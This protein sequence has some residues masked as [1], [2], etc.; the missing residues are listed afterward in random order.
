MDALSRYLLIPADYSPFVG[1]LRWSANGEAIEYDDGT[2]FVFAP[3]LAL[4]LEGLTSVRRPL[5]FA[6]VLHLLYLLG[7]GK[8]EGDFRPRV[9]TRAFE[10][11]GRP[12]RNAGTLCG[13]LCRILPGMTESFD[14]AQLCRRL[15]SPALMVE[16]R[17]RM[18]LGDSDVDSLA[19][20]PLESPALEKHFLDA[21]SRFTVKEL[22]QWLRYGCIPPSDAGEEVARAVPT[23]QPRTLRGVLSHLVQQRRLAGAVPFVAQMVSALALPPRRLTDREL[24]MGGYADVA[25]RGHPEQILPS[26]FAIDE[27]EFV[28]RFA[29][30]ELLYFRREEPHARVNEELVLLLDQ[31]VRTWG[32][33][34]LVLGAA[35]L[36]FGKRADKRGLPVFLATTSNEGRLLDPLQAEDKQVA[37]LV[38]A[39]DLSANPG[40]ALER[41]LEQQPAATAA[42]RD[43]VLLTHPRSLGDADVAAAARRV[44]RDTRL[45]AVTV[46][47]H[48]AVQLSALRHGTPVKLSQFQVDFSLA[49]APVANDVEPVRPAEP[50]AAWRG[51]VEPVP[52][53]FRFGV[54]HG[55]SPHLFDFDLSGEWMVEV[56]QRG[57]LHAWQPDGPGMEVLPR[58]FVDGAVLNPVDA[59]LGVAGG[60]VACGIVQNKP[61][62]VHYDFTL[63]KVTA[64]VLGPSQHQSWAW[65][66][67]SDFHSVVARCGQEVHAVDLTS[68][69]RISSPS[70]VENTVRAARAWKRVSDLSLV[71]DGFRNPRTVLLLPT[72][73]PHPPQ[74]YLRI[75]EKKGE[76]LLGGVTP[77]WR[78]FAPVADGKPM[79]L[80]RLLTGQY[81]GNVLALLSAHD[82]PYQLKLRL[83]RGPNSVSLGE[84]SQARNH[85][86]FALSADGRRLARQTGPHQVEVRRVDNGLSQLAISPRGRCH[87]DVQVELGE[88]WLTMQVGKMKHLVRWDGP[89]LDVKMTLT[90]KATFVRQE[91]AHTNLRTSRVRLT[92]QSLPRSVEYDMRRFSAGVIGVLNVAVDCFG[93][94][95]IFERTG[96]LVCMFFVF[97]DQFAAWLPDG[98]RCG[99]ASLIGGPDY[100]TSN[101]TVSYAC[102][103]LDSSASPPPTPSAG[104]VKI[105]RALREAW[106]RSLEAKP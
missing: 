41:V 81:A 77:P 76:M 39:S 106:Q 28:R 16:I 3:Q 45:F 25:T 17:L 96:E 27:V 91:L 70:P 82:A 72:N 83:F 52:F 9:L 97:R 86:H 80:G 100:S 88:M 12:L 89:A 40:L 78:P 71:G 10:E 2:T 56:G 15:A 57:I 99:P 93:Q 66:Y 98:T 92:R 23:G 7:Y 37:D 65:C 103:G 8:E 31:G 63:R 94:V 14:M 20:P 48:G 42:L 67:F 105:G 43:I 13:L 85:V 68:G 69:T 50:L 30:N 1:R 95:A 102:S 36:A 29:E 5:H 101:I 87:Q 104:A 38:E 24:P 11:T 73:K 74:P 60:F 4:F 62:A 53:P 47:D 35:V 49:N 75:Y 22:R 18:T 51:D 90:D 26:Q 58:G 46:D 44:P 54:I 33:V 79:D 6:F 59:L 34:R 84:I 21:L 64:H 61:V 32:E 19:V 55:Q